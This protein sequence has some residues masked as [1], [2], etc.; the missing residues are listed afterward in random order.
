MEKIRFFS[1]AKEILEKTAVAALMT[2]FVRDR[3]V[4]YIVCHSNERGI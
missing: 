1:D 3:K 2:E 4:I